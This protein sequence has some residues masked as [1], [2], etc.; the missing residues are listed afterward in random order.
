MQI[1][2]LSGPVAS[3]ALLILARIPS[4]SCLMSALPP[5]ADPRVITAGLESAKN[6]TAAPDIQ[7]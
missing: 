6:G 3:A 7:R 4:C 2:V 1:R 5:K